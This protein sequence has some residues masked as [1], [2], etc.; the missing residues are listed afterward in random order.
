MNY[1][2]QLLRLKKIG[3]IFTTS[4]IIKK[5]LQNLEID[6]ALRLPPKDGFSLGDF[7]IFQKLN[8]L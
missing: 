3:N 6:A 8:N 4:I 5:L 1:V 7:E 2:C